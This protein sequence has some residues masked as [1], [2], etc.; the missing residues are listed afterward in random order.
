MLQQMRQMKMFVFWF[1]AVVFVVGFVFLGGLDI[2][3]GRSHDVNVAGVINGQ[4]INYDVYNRYVTQYSEM[5]KQRFQRDELTQADYDRID[6]EAWDGLVSDVL[7]NQEA[8]RLGIRAQDEDIVSTITQNPP[9]WI[10]QRFNDDKGQFDVAAFQQAVN[11]PTYDWGPRRVLV[12]RGAALAEVAA[13][14]A[15]RCQRQ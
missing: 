9:E 13:D 12:A 2:P 11:D 6:G 3:K 4:K 10:R 14:G 1:V 15:R 5:E 8:K 7:V